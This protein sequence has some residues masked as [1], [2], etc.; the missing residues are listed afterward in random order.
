MIKVCVYLP[1]IVGFRSIVTV[2]TL[3]CLQYKAFRR[4]AAVSNLWVSRVP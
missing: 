1:V 4:G 3:L 2:L